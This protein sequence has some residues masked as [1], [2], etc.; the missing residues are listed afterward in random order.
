MPKVADEFDFKGFRALAGEYAKQRNECARQSRQAYQN[1]DGRRAKELS[2]QKKEYA[3]KMKSA[4]RAAAQETFDHHNASGTRSPNEIDLH[5]LFVPEAIEY[6]KKYVNVVEKMQCRDLIV[7]VGRG[8]H[9]EGGPKIKPAVIEYAKKHKM[10][11]E[12][13]SPRVGCIR[14]ESQVPLKPRN[15]FDD[16]PKV[17]YPSAPRYPIS[18]PV[19]YPTVPPTFVT[20]DFDDTPYTTNTSRALP[21]FTRPRSRAS[22]G[23]EVKMC[24]CPPAFLAILL[25]ICVALS[26]FLAVILINILGPWGFSGV[27][28]A[29]LILVSCGWCCCGKK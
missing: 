8:K 26:G 25:M 27:V 22:S 3:R 13:D 9:S 19:R 18:A 24:S 2:N 14:I 15:T 23:R 5:G 1:G 11:Y 16:L 29:I 21:F 17:H 10:T 28:F 20:I 12:V 7:I 4:N 6:L